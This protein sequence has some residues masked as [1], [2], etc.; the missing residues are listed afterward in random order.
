MQPVIDLFSKGG[1]AMYPLLLC[2]LLGVA[3]TI[4]RFYSLS[5]ANSDPKKLMTKV[6]EALRNK[7]YRVAVGY[8]EATPG[9]VAKALSSAINLHDRAPEE[10]RE[11]VNEAVLSEIP[12]LERGLP[13]LS[14]VTTIS[15]LLGLLGTITGLMKLFSV[16]AGGDIGNSAALSR[17]IAEALITT[18]TGLILAITFMFFHNI[19]ATRVDRI[20]NQ[21]EKS[22]T[23]LMNFIRM[24]V[25]SDV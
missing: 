7:D 6:K 17:G 4:E 14:T 1:F 22:V 16:I 24:E 23:E 5:R 11:G 8:C 21:I 15:P 19:L 13:T 2:S 18:A 20:I 25:R 9:P 3:I 10:I 12:R